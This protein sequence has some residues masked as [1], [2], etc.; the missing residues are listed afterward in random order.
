MSERPLSSSALYVARPTIRVNGQEQ[1]RIDEL[2]LRMEM[3][4]RE[5]GLSTLEL[6]FTNV[7]SEES[8]SA[9][10]AFED[11]SV[12][13]L[14]DSVNVYCGEEANPTE[15][16]RGVISGLEADFPEEQSPTLVLLAEDKLQKARLKR[17]SRTHQNLSL[18]T[19]A[20]N[21]A[22]DLG[23]TPR[24]SGFSDDIGTH[25]QLNESDLAFLRRL[26]ARHDGDLQVV[27]DELHVSPRG[28]VQR[29][30]IELRHKGQLRRATILADLAHQVNEVTVTGWDAARGSRIKGHSDGAQR[31][32][33]G[34]RAGPELLSS[35]LGRRAHQIS[36]LAVNNDS[37]ARALAE[38]AFDERQRR[39]V[40][41]NGTADGNPAIRVG[42]HVSI[43]EVSRRFSNTY[44]VTW[45]CHRFDLESGYE[46]DFRAECAFLGRP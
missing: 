31:G 6:R 1:E 20:R 14:G 27:G 37:E 30:A 10:F 22:S 3:I 4:E 15:V 38:A 16:F 32:P 45:C 34:G 36:H 40:T 13:K 24:V 19:L 29:G 42:T 46:T 5:D 7:A 18:A 12:F 26:L 17:R 2:L 41:V 25:V 39:F 33:G 8:G 44:Y 35:A 11:E 21:V 23:L 28:Q 9:K 43:S